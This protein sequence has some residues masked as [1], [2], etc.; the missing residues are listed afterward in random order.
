MRVWGWSQDNGAEE[1]WNIEVTR[2]V[3]VDL[4]W[5]C[6]L[7]GAM[8]SGDRPRVITLAA[9]DA[10]AFARDTAACRT[11]G[12]FTVS[13]VRAAAATTARVNAS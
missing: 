5:R 10:R 8:M 6:W 11:R 7:F 3:Y 13:T 1:P 12:S 4:D 9:S 2:G